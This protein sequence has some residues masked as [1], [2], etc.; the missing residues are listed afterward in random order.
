MPQFSSSW[1]KHW[2]NVATL[3]LVHPEN[4]Q[5]PP[6][7][8]LASLSSCFRLKCWTPGFIFSVW[9]IQHWKTSQIQ[10]AESV[11]LKDSVKW[12]VMTAAGQSED[13]STGTIRAEPEQFIV[14]VLKCF[15]SWGSVTLI[16]LLSTQLSLKESSL[17]EMSFTAAVSCLC[18]GWPLTSLNQAASVQSAIVPQ[19]ISSSL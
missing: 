6:S 4:I 19:N 12:W 11:Y 14:Q 1:H 17:E 9:L 5:C 2:F 10:T 15:I 7:S 18:I 8:P 16:L 13:I 3:R